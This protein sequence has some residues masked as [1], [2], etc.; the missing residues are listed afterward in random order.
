MDLLVEQDGLRQKQKEGWCLNPEQKPT[1]FGWGWKEE[2]WWEQNSV[3]LRIKGFL[4]GR[5][6]GWDAACWGGMGWVA[7]P[8]KRDCRIFHSHLTA[9]EAK[10]RRSERTWRWPGDDWTQASWS[11]EQDVEAAE[12]SGAS[13]A[14]Y[15]KMVGVSMATGE[16]QWQRAPSALGETPGPQHNRGERGVGVPEGPGFGWT[17]I[18]GH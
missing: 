14:T 6:R 17:W 2:K 9:E 18:L 13:D 5:V 11:P 8:S 16:A 1:S 15:T 10:A 3:G 7:H 12:E 4:L